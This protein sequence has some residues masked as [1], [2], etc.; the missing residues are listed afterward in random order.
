M[1]IMLRQARGMEVVWWAPPDSR[2]A[3][4]SSRFVGDGPLPSLILRLT[5]TF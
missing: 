3:M 5:A 1:K 4:D 2:E